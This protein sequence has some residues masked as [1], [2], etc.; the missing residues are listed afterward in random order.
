MPIFCVLGNSDQDSDQN[1]IDIGDDANIGSYEL[2]NKQVELKDNKNVR[3]ENFQGNTI[4][5]KIYS[6]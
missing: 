3:E 4:T 6:E 2:E 5:W 1:V